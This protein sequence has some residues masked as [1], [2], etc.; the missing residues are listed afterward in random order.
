MTLI[1]ASILT[2]ERKRVLFIGV[3]VVQNSAQYSLLSS[4]RVQAYMICNQTTKEILNE[5]KIPLKHAKE[6]E[7]YKLETN[8]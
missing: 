1:V 5:K 7:Q 8:S 6:M 3:K 2:N 4:V